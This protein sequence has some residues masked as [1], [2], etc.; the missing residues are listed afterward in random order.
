MSNVQISQELFG[1]LC[2]YH[3]LD[4]HSAAECIQQLLEAKLDAIAK[5]ELYTQSKT[6]DTPEE[7]EKA[8]Q[9]YLD[10][11]GMSADFRY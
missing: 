11:I 9:A 6:A 4:D 10:R 2:M 5:R 8:R 3:L 7:R 1:L